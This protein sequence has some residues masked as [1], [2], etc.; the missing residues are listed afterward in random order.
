MNFFIK[1]SLHIN[2]DILSTKHQQKCPKYQ[3]IKPI[4]TLSSVK[5]PVNL[6]NRSN[7]LVKGQQVFV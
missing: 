7:L 4:I 1:L 6:Y 3:N 2:Y 5:F